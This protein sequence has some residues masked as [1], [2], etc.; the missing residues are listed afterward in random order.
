MEGKDYVILGLLGVGAVGVIYLVLQKDRAEE[1]DK[2]LKE[3]ELLLDDLRSEMEVVG[4]ELQNAQYPMSQEVADGIMRDLAP[5]EGKIIKLQAMNQRLQE[6]NHNQ[7]IGDLITDKIKEGLDA[8]LIFLEWAAIAVLVGAVLAKGAM[9][10]GPKLMKSIVEWIKGDRGGPPPPWTCGGCGA[11]FGSEAGL[12]SHIQ[13][14]HPPTSDNNAIMQAQ[15]QFQTLS[16]MTQ[17]SVTSASGVYE[18]AGWSWPSL[19]QMDLQSLGYGSMI[20]ENLG[21]ATVTEMFVLQSMR[22]LILF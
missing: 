18:R 6:L 16:S 4:M 22:I 12:I 7:S 13:T 5:F 15:A 9:Y 14:N 2:L 8:V 20:L 1:I 3:Q 19:P 10:L 21:A 11:Q 17:L